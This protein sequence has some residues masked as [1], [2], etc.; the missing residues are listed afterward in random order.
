MKALLKGKM[1]TVFF[2]DGDIVT[3]TEA[4]KAMYLRVIEMTDESEVRTIVVPDLSDA[5]ATVLVKKDGMDTVDMLIEDDIFFREGDAVYR[6]GIKLSMPEMV[7]DEYL[8]AY[9][10]R[11][12][13]SARFQTIDNFWKW[14]SLCPN[15]ESRED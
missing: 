6:T 12:E 4:D 8:K 7:L 2:S 1:L 9:I 5:E 11:D 13:Q 3:N 10:G 14:L 15:A